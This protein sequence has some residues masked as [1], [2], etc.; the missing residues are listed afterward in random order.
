MRAA[1]LVVL[2]QSLVVQAAGPP[3]EGPAVKLKP[4][5]TWEARS[6]EGLPASGKRKV[7]LIE[8]QDVLAARWRGL[9]PGVDA[10][11]IDFGSNFLVE[12]VYPGGQFS[13]SGLLVGRGGEA[14]IAGSG[15][16][17]PVAVPKGLWH[18]LAVFPRGKVRIVEGQKVAA[19]VPALEARP[20]LWWSG[21]GRAHSAG[22][23]SALKQSVT[24]ISGPKQFA[25][26]WKRLG[27]KAAAPTVNFNEYFV[28]VVN[29]PLGLDLSAPFGKLCIDAK[30]DAKVVGL[31][32]H[33][34]DRD[35][36]A[37][38]STLAVFPRT[39]VRSVEGKK[40][41]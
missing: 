31:N 38:S 21:L 14:A 7:Y 2:A 34:D 18:V 32:A 22:P 20:A 37:I 5:R 10:P 27:L 1:L 17:Q 26:V 35:S 25:G 30:G 13:L 23:A 24:L 12:V 3:F 36:I 29:R 16:K 39:G 15:W 40:L 41:P 8:R 19:R 6:Q 11:K 28:V 9:Y 4:L 33:A